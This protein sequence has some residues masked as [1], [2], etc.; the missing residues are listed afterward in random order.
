[1]NEAPK[2]HAKLKKPGAEGS[3][4]HAVRFRFYE[5][6]RKGKFLWR[7]QADERLPGAGGG[8]GRG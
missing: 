2:P 1:M 3:S 6:F 8:A 7:Q 4:L 5:M